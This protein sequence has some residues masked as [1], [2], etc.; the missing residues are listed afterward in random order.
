[1]HPEAVDILDN[2]LQNNAVIRKEYEADH[3]LKN[4]PRITNIGK[5]LNS[6]R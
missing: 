1:M 4:D 6:C 5:F 3:K 2:L